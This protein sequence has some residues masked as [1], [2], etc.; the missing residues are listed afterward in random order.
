[1]QNNVNSISAS[2]KGN[3]TATAKRLSNK[4]QIN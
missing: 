4:G 2:G 1:M 3:A